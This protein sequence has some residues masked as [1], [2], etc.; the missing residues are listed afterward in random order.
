MWSWLLWWRPP[1]V[2][3]QVLIS[4]VSDPDAGIQGVL[5]RQRGAWLGL[6]RASY[7]KT[8]ADARVMDGE[9]LVHRSNVAFLQAYEE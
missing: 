8:G 9:V 6:R 4:L 7:L 5:V 3:R 1:C 2:N